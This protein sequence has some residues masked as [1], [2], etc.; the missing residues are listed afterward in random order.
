MAEYAEPGEQPSAVQLVRAFVN[1]NGNS[2]SKSGH[3]SGSSPIYRP[4][5]TAHPGLPL[6][7]ATP[8]QPTALTVEGHQQPYYHEELV[9]KPRSHDFAMTAKTVQ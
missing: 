8:S 3:R 1:P 6:Y 2:Y 9:S 4:R 7:A 5:Q